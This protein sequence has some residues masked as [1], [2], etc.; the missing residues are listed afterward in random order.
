MPSRACLQR[1]RTDNGQ[2]YLNNIATV[3][4]GSNIDLSPITLL[5]KNTKHDVRT[6]PHSCDE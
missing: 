1:C 4:L 6:G 3:P 5:D 2:I